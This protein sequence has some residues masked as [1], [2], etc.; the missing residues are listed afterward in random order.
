MKMASVMGLGDLS[1]QIL[2]QNG[3]DITCFKEFVTLLF[4]VLG[5][6]NNADL[7]DFTVHSSLI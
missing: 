2:E 5:F 7:K 6:K 1:L 4:T 3:T